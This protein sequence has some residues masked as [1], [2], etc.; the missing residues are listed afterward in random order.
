MGREFPYLLLNRHAVDEHLA[1]H[2]ATFGGLVQQGLDQGGFTRSTRP[3]HCQQRPC[4]EERERQTDRETDIKTEEIERHRER[5]RHRERRRETQR[6]KRKGERVGA[7]H[8]ERER[9]SLSH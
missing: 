3:H 1:C 7:R 8:R 4:G 6:E 2:V 5:Q 9:D